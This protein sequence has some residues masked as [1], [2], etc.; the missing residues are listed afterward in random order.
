MYFAY[1][2][3]SD[4]KKYPWIDI[5]SCDQKINRRNLDNGD[6]LLYVRNR[7]YFLMNIELH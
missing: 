2:V 5:C 1:H 3:F 7:D 4:R 6:D